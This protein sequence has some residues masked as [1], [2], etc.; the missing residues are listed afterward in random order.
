MSTLIIVFVGVFLCIM[1]VYAR[2]RYG[3]PEMYWILPLG[4]IMSIIGIIMYV[5][6]VLNKLGFF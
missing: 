2:V 5:I 1:G 6:Y 3:N 4:I